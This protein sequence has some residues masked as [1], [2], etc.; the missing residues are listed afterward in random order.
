VLRVGVAPPDSPAR[1]VF[2][3][4]CRALEVDADLREIDLAPDAAAAESR[5]VVAEVRDSGDVFGA[6]IEGAG[7]AV[8]RDC[9]ALIETI[10]PDA[11]AL[12][13][14]TVLSKRSGGL[15]GENSD[16]DAQRAVLAQLLPPNYWADGRRTAVVLGGGSRARALAFGLSRA[17]RAGPL[18]VAVVERDLDR[19]SVIQQRVG[20]PG[21]RPGSLEVV[22]PTAGTADDVVGAAPPGSLVVNAAGP[23]AVPVSP[24][25]R[26]PPEA[27]V[28]DLGA[29]RDPPF[30]RAARDQAVARRLVVEDGWRYFVSSWLSALARV[31]HHRA[32]TWAEVDAALAAAEPHRPL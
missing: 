5:R 21:A 19:R 6:L 13:E 23:D 2:P 25:V 28:W 10:D 16:V 27:V 11:R 31:L 1:W 9:A 8:Y 3:S 18:R 32:A 7:P 12:E 17:D 26:F 20:G 14:V 15:V 30:L 22:T 29:L 4:L 24:S